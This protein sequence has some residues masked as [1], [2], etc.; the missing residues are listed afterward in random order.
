MAVNAAS[1]LP[2]AHSPRIPASSYASLATSMQAARTLS[3]TTEEAS[4]RC[5]ITDPCA[6]TKCERRTSD[7]NACEGVSWTAGAIDHV[8]A[9]GGHLVTDGSELR[10]S[11]QA[12]R[13]RKQIQVL[14]GNVPAV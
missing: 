3:A 6:L 14:N 9:P 4:A 13:H 2:S 10:G 5:D 8:I 12:V 7:T 1:H 11:Q